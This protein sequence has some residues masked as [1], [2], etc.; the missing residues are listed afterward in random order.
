VRS[1][2]RAR[3]RCPCMSRRSAV[4]RV[5]APVIPAAGSL[6]ARSSGR[7]G[8]RFWPFLVVLTLWLP[9]RLLAVRPWETWSAVA[10]GLCQVLAWALVVAVIILATAT[11][12]GHALAGRIGGSAV[13]IYEVWQ[14]RLPTDYATG[15]LGRFL[16]L[17]L[18]GVVRPPATDWS[19]GAVNWWSASWTIADVLLVMVLGITVSL[20]P[21]RIPR[22]AVPVGTGN[23]A[24]AVAVVAVLVAAPASLS[25][26]VLGGAASLR[27]A[28]SFMG[29]NMVLMAA[30]AMLGLLAM[31]Y[32]VDRRCVVA[33]FAAVGLDAG[34]GALGGGDPWGGPQRLGAPLDTSGQLETKSTVLLLL[35][36]TVAVCLALLSIGP[37]S[38]AMQALQGHPGVATVLGLVANVDFRTTGSTQQWREDPQVSA[39]PSLSTEVGITAVGPPIGGTP[40]SASDGPVSGNRYVPTNSQ[41]GS[42]QPR[43]VRICRSAQPLASARCSP[44]SP[45]LRSRGNASKSGQTRVRGNPR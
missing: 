43:T 5:V 15:V 44:W 21:G 16:A 20:H 31:A 4:G 10:G 17:P 19:P 23:V 35:V 42:A 14:H 25:G 30:A 28:M 45:L 8:L 3:G 29:A 32:R 18:A 41:S 11:A 12:S 6:S 26:L 36:I 9:A 24:V 39:V 22:R 38:R 1:S 13:I 34:A 27:S 37:L 33:L 7:T 2:R 40:S